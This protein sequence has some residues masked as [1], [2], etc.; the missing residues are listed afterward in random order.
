MLV[1]LRTPVQH[2]RLTTTEKNFVV[3]DGYRADT[4][5]INLEFTSHNNYY[6]KVKLIAITINVELRL[7]STKFLYMKE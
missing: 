2:K 7:L 5:L 3:A 6:S 1:S 4:V